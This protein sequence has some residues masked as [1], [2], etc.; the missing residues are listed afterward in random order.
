MREDL[1]KIISALIYD[2]AGSS[3]TK[4]VCKGLDTLKENWPGLTEIE[5]KEIIAISLSLQ[6]IDEEYNK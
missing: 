5:K 2:L 3:R 6:T 1:T 4:S